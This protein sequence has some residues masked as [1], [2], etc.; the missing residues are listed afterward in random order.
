M[1]DLLSETFYR[2]RL[3]RGHEPA[4]TQA[5]LARSAD[6]MEAM[7]AAYALMAH[8]DGEVAGAERQRAFALL[9]Q[10]PAMTVFSREEIAAEMAEH[11][12]NFR[13][14]PEVAQEIA[15]EK[16]VR[17]VHERQA[18]SAV[19]SACRE[20]IPADGVAH[21]AEYRQLAEIKALLGH[22]DAWG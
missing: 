16:V 20:I 6:L 9:R 18:S 17:I 13:L 7:V 4:G 8:A 15:R 22:A 2:T 21:P 10:N 1:E 12:A 19:I 14:D 11:E 5:A 3:E